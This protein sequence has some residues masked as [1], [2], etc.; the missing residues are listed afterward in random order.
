MNSL[1]AL[2]Q[3]KLRPLGTGQR[4]I[5][6]VANHEFLARMT[7]IELNS[8]LL[9]PAISLALEEIAKELLLQRNSIIV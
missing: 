3:V 1:A 6:F 4:P 7:D 8:W 2:G 5:V 9:V